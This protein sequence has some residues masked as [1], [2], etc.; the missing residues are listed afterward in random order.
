MRAL[1]VVGR[2][3]N[4]RRESG[5]SWSEWEMML[6]IMRQLGPLSLASGCRGSAAGVRIGIIQCARLRQSDVHGR[7]LRLQIW[8]CQFMFLTATL[9]YCHD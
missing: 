8:S 2:C 4:D 6:V 9:L 3:K 5:K 1:I 7:A